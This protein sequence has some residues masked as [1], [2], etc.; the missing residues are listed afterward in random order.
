MKSGLECTRPGGMRPG[1]LC[2]IYM[3][4]MFFLEAVPM[5]EMHI[6][7]AAWKGFLKACGFKAQRRSGSFLHAFCVPLRIIL[8]K[9][10]KDRHS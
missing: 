8:D 4:N 9:Y 5:P 1:G 10:A 3:K 2:C 6:L 7:A